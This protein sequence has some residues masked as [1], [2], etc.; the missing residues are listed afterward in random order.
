MTND[1]L[2]F[3]MF[4]LIVGIALGHRIAV[5]SARRSENKTR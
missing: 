3:L 2:A 4:G 5:W 1:E